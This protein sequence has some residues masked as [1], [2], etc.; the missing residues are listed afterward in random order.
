MQFYLW[1]FVI[2]VILLLHDAPTFYIVKQGSADLKFR[3]AAFGVVPGKEPQ[4]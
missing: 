3:S 2:P 1:A 4:T